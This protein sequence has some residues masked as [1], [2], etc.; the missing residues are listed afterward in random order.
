MMTMH[1]SSSSISSISSL[2]SIDDSDDG[3]STTSS[4]I[5]DVAKSLLELAHRVFQ[6]VEDET[7]IFGQKKTIADFTEAE[8]VS[9][10]RFRKNDLQHVQLPTTIIL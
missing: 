10:F 2:S 4:L 1:D 6:S 7:I 9:D 5:L 8:C 3:S